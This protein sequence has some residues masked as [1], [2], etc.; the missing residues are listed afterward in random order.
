MDRQGR[1]GPA[2][3]GCRDCKGTPAFRLRHG[4]QFGAASDCTAAWAPQ[5]AGR[6]RCA[7]GILPGLWAAVRPFWAETPDMFG[8]HAV[9]V[10][11]LSGLPKIEETRTWMRMPRNFGGP[12]Q[13]H[14]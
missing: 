14:S 7:V 5:R 9:V 2:H 12:N 6:R 10:L 1:L 11:R 3:D 13:R 8:D 4:A